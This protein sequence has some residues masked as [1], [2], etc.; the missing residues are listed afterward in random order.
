MIDELEDT[1]VQYY[2]FSFDH[3][4]DWI[5]KSIIS[6]E[7]DFKQRNFNIAVNISD[8]Q[9]T[10]VLITSENLKFKDVPS[11]IFLMMHLA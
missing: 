10:E 2:Q 6:A 3:L 9:S 4:E 8:Y 1:K 7:R 5:G 11:Y